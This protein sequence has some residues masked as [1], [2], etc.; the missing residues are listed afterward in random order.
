[1][2]DMLNW[3]DRLKIIIIG[4]IVKKI[5]FIGISPSLKFKIVLTKVIK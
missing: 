5:A 1:M 4:I 2:F 3:V